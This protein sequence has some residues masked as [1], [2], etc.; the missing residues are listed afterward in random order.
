M[1][2]P[3][4]VAAVSPGALGHR[5][6]RAAR[7]TRNEHAPPSDNNKNNKKKIKKKKYKKANDVL[8]ATI[9]HIFT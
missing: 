8:L 4:A 6:E 7:C 5:I 1:A 9:Q 3:Q 2:C